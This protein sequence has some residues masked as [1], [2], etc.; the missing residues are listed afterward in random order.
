VQNASNGTLTEPFQTANG[1][2]ALLQSGYGET[3]SVSTSGTQ[4]I[5]NL[6]LPLVADSENVPLALNLG[7]GLSFNSSSSIHMEITANFN[8]SFGVDASTGNF[9]VVASN[10]PVLQISGG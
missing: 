10:Q 1:L 3:A 4:I 2:L 9:F 8:V 5:Y 6:Q 7:P